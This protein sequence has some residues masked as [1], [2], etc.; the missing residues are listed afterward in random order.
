MRYLITIIWALLISLVISYVLTSMA[1]EELRMAPIFFLVA[2]FS[3]VTF[4][5]G[6]GILKEDK[7]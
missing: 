3:I 2:I 1:G 6:D 5:V 4:I 7:K